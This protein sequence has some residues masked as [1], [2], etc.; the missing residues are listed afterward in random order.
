MSIDLLCR[1]HW[2]KKHV[3][4]ALLLKCKPLLG[5]MR[6][7]EKLYT[8]TKFEVDHMHSCERRKIASFLHV[9]KLT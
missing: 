6:T 3:L 1:A 5:K 9:T 8:A 7:V 2:S 4:E